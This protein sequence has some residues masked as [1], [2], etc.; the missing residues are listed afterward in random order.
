MDKQG[1]WEQSA[2]SSLPKPALGAQ[3]YAGTLQGPRKVVCRGWPPKLPWSLRCHSVVHTAPAPQWCRWTWLSAGGLVTRHLW[4][5]RTEGGRRRTQTST[6]LWYHSH[7][8]SGWL[9]PP[10]ERKMVMANL[11]FIQM[12]HSLLDSHGSYRRDTS[13]HWFCV[14]MSPKLAKQNVKIVHTIR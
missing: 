13:T 11:T 4:L 12:S 2:S 5:C 6:H 3:T 10:G 1:M 14:C 7:I 8:D 9:S